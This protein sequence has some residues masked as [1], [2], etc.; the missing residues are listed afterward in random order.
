MSEPTKPIHL[1]FTV[2]VDSREKAPYT[3]T[4]LTADAAQKTADAAQ[5]VAD[6]AEAK[7]EEVK[8]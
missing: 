3:F 5:N 1:P 2:A 6:K 8:K 7:A 4:G